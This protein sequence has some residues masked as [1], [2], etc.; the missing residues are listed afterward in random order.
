MRC[1]RARSVP[2]TADP[3]TRSRQT[4][5]TGDP[6]DMSAHGV[7]DRDDLDFMPD[8]HAATR[9]RGRRF[10]YI[11]TVLPVGFFGVMGVWANYAVLYAVNLGAATAVPSSPHPG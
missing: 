4:G 6:R 8:V 2:A 5:R 9:H 7:Y 1:A 11:L 3:T 10:A